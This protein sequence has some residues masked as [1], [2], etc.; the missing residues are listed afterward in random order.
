MLASAAGVGFVSFL[1]SYAVDS[2]MS[3]GAAGLLLGG[4]SLMATCSRIGLGLFAD[5]AGQEPLRP[6]AA[7]LAASVGGYLLLI[8]GE[9]R[10]RPGGADGGSARLGLARRPQPGGGPAG[11]TPRPWAV[12]VLM[13]GLFT[14]AVAGPL[15]VGLLAEQDPFAAAWITCA[16][17][18]LLAALT[19]QLNPPAGGRTARL[20]RAAATIHVP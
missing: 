5:R 12:G 3:E 20:T 17:L 14:G 7:M 19:L 9:S 18:A 6:V 13:T 2:G 15:I 8:S 4:V 16:A 1:V 11:R 10:H